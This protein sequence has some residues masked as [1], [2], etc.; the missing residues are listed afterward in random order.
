VTVAEL[1]DRLRAFDP[2]ARVVVPGEGLFAGGWVDA[3]GVSLV[4]LA[5]DD[6]LGYIAAEDAAEDAEGVNCVGIN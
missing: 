1:I 5:K 4:P 3:R 6:R 2:E